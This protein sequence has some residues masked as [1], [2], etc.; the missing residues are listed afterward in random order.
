VVRWVDK[1]NITI[2]I[3]HNPFKTWEERVLWVLE[4]CEST[5]QL[6][7]E[8]LNAY[9]IFRSKSSSRREVSWLPYIA[10]ADDCRWNLKYPTDLCSGGYN[11]FLLFLQC[12]WSK[13]TKW[14]SSRVIG[15]KI[16]WNFMLP[17]D[18]FF[19]CI[20]DIN[21]HFTTHLIEEIKLL[22][23]VFLH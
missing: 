6:L 15:K 20:F 16:L 5:I 3:M 11:E 22:G 17:R 1:R 18:V 8:H 21:V 19:T 9:F 12:N 7:D 13:S 4:K 10:Y 2:H 14:R 23:P